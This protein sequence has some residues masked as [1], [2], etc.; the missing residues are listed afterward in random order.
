MI[1]YTEKDEGFAELMRK[2]ELNPS[3]LILPR[4]VPC[5]FTTV[6]LTNVVSCGIV[7]D[8]SNTTY[9]KYIVSGKSD[10]CGDKLVGIIL[11]E[12]DITLYTGELWS[13]PVYEVS[14]GDIVYTLIG[15]KVQLSTGEVKEWVG[16]T[17]L[18]CRVYK[19][20]DHEVF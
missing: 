5:I 19:V 14:P 15:D 20:A 11:L 3:G 17:E 4:E 10:S 12:S 8:K 6:I 18:M 2:A 13:L 16:N 9:T 1:H 7:I